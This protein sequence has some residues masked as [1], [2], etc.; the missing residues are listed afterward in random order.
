[1]KPLF[2]FLL[3]FCCSNLYSQDSL[4]I[5]QID[6]L[7]TT[8]AYS[9]LPSRL[10]STSQDYPTLGLSMKTYITMLIDDKELKKY[11]YRVNTVRQE[12]GISKQL[13]TGSAFYYD[14]NKLIKVEEFGIQ[15][16]KEQHF[17]WYFFDDQCFYHTL[18]SEKAESRIP[19]LLTISNGILRQNI[20]QN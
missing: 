8:I 15:D 19:L 6:S 14:R 12:N 16:G 9:N 18:K 10:D 20:K 7:V 2:I 17:T 1:M 11:V 5:K 4:K 3:L 13:I